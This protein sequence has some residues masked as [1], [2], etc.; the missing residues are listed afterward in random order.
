MIKFLIKKQVFPKLSLAKIK[1]K[2]IFL[3]RQIKKAFNDKI[4][5]NKLGNKDMPAR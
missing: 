3:G 5:K 1:E 4:F 2:K